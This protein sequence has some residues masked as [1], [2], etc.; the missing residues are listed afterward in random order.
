MIPGPYKLLI[1]LQASMQSDRKTFEQLAEVLTNNYSPLPSK[2]IQKFQFNTRTRQPG[3]SVFTYIAELRRL[4]KFLQLRRQAQLNSNLTILAI[5]EVELITNLPTADSWKNTVG[6]AE[7]KDR[8]QRCAGA[9]PR[10]ESP[11][12]RRL[13]EKLKTSRS[14][15]HVL[16]RW[17]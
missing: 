13:T 4:A 14:I 17:F 16:W 7:R 11:M 6:T 10:I 8:L 2:V 12:S 1:G 3:E 15:Q 9:S 5:V